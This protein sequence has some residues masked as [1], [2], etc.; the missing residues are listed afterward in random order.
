[1]TGYPKTDLSTFVL[2]LMIYLMSY[3]L[4]LMFILCRMS[5]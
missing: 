2:D 5:P 3:E 1:M 4:C